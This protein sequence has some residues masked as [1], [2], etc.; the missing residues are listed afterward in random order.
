MAIKDWLNSVTSAASKATSKS[1]ASTE[2]KLTIDDLITLE[3]YD[4]ALEK[5]KK[6]VKANKGNYRA[7][8][9][10]ADIYLKT[11]Q[12]GEGIEEYLSIADRYTS[13]GFFDKG[14]ALVAKLARMI[15]HEEKLEAKMASIRRSK[16]LE[17]RR[18]LI[19]SEL[20]ATP[21]AIEVRQHWP[22]LIQGP[23][24]EVL[25]REQLTKLFPLLSIV[26]L[27]AGDVLA[28]KDESK[29]ELY[30]IL[31]GEIGAEVV[32]AT[33]SATD[34]RIFHGGD[35]IG[36]RALLKREPWPATYR[37][38]KATK[39]LVLGREGLAQALVGEEDPRAF[40]NTLRMQENDDHVAESASKVKAVDP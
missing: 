20:G 10:L 18:Q 11:G 33:G 12:A 5:L 24:V 14:Y 27:A 13:E 28:K 30:V 3:R 6:R 4:E 40:L 26:R 21:W 19:V 16:R 39:V 8:I 32:L 34:L 1:S 17:H 35:I 15:P 23:I 2:E 9:Q 22:E 7:R 36:D 37:A 38:K 25:S 29:E 31:T